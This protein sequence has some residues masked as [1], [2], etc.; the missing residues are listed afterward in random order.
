MGYSGLKLAD[1]ATPL[2][3]TPPLP[4]PLAGHVAIRVKNVE[5]SRDFYVGTLGFIEMLRLERDGKLWLAYLRVSDDQIL[6]IASETEESPGRGDEAAG[7]GHVCFAVPDIDLCMQGIEAAG[8]YLHRPI[9]LP[10]DNSQ[11]WVRDPDDRHIQLVQMARNSS[12]DAAIARLNA[13]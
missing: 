2:R 7:Y 5:T 9:G 13:N 8:V 12:W 6:E 4:V 1:G 10:N 3:A 11:C